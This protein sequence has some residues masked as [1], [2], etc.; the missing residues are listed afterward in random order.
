[1]TN[2]F[3]TDGVR[4]VANSYPITPDMVLRFGMAAGQYFKKTSCMQ[5]V[6]IGKDTRLS[7]Y[8]IES[9]LTAGFSS[10]GIEVILVGPLPTP[11]ISMLVKSLRADLGVMISASHNMYQD[12]GIKFFDH[13]GHK[14]S[15]KIEEEISSKV[16]ANAFEEALAPPDAIGKVKR[17][18]D[19][20]GRY[21]E[22]VKRSFPRFLNLQGLRIVVD[23]ANGAAYH[24]APTIFW[25]LGAE[26]VNINCQPNGY[27][28]NLE[29]GSTAP[30]G[31]IQKVLETRADIGIAFDGDADRVLIVDEKG[32]VLDGDNLIAL[33]AKEMQEANTLRSN[34]VVVTHMT[35]SAFDVYLHTLGIEVHRTNI[36]DRYVTEGMKQIGANLGGEQSG[37][38]VLSDYAA[39]GD[40]MLA[41]LQVLAALVRT[42]KPISE[43]GNL[44][45]LY[46]QTMLNVHY[47]QQNPLNDPKVQSAL[48]TLQKDANNA[49]FLIRK[50]G[51]EKKIRILVEGQ[52]KIYVQKLATEA[53]FIIKQH[54]ADN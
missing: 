10:L 44:F 38:I 16:L 21:I 1:M 26:V 7:G 54:V 3:G 19:A 36:G 30:N 33:I 5:R 22:H 41:A 25:E 8:M 49:R 23:C 37:H 34:K 11:A 6:I 27:N 48:A 29:C 18:D 15:D 4:G 2:L 14:L 51:T 45:H 53:A 32:H 50:S 52:D 13:N 31:L 28:I 17:L 24:L 42:K 39:T 12:N 43:M 9:A 35:N 40:G 46:P 47:H 20:A